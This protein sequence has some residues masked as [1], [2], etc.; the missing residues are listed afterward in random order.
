MGRSHKD[1]QAEQRSN[2]TSHAG[3]RDRCAYWVEAGVKGEA[4][5]PEGRL[6]KSRQKV[7]E[8]GENSQILTNHPS[9]SLGDEF[10]VP[11]A[12][13]PQVPYI[14]CVVSSISR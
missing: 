13:D 4:W 1:C 3:E 14:K 8:Q 10:Q 5:E 2:A 6:G 9:V 12:T 11:N 7:V